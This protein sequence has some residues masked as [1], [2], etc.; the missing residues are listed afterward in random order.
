M[1]RK[2]WSDAARA[3]SAQVRKAKALRKPSATGAKGRSLRVRGR[4]LRSTKRSSLAKRGTRGNKSGSVPA[5]KRRNSVSRQVAVRRSRRGQ[6]SRTPAQ[7]RKTRSTKR[8]VASR[9]SSL[10]GH[11]T[12][13]RRN[14][15]RRQIGLKKANSSVRR[16]QRSRKTTRKIAGRR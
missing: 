12:R 3:K 8:M 14:A 5:G 16:Y 6:A 4:A 2:G 11:N 13:G 15:G 10:P 7:K 9:K 1:V